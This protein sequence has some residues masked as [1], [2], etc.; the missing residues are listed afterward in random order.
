MTLHDFHTICPRINMLTVGDVFCNEPDNVVCN[1]ECLPQL[2]VHSSS[3]LNMSD[4]DND[5]SNWQDFYEEKLNGARKVFTPSVDT[6]KRVL[7]KIPVKNIVAQY[8]PEAVQKVQFLPRY[9]Y[10]DKVLRIG[11]IGAIGPHKGVNK[12]KE[13]VSYIE[14]SGLSIEI[15][16]FGYTSDN[17]FFERFDFVTITGAYKRTE[18]EMLLSNYSVHVMF[19]SSIW[20]ETF[21]YTYSEVIR[22]GIPIVTFDI[23]AIPERAEKNKNVLILDTSI[24]VSAVVA[25]IVSFV[26]RLQPNSIEVG[27]EYQSIVEGY[28][29]LSRKKPL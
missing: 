27:C 9:V 7:E 10:G 18:L 15:V 13:L 17:E 24:E 16:I 22:Q 29:K 3:Y 23:G 26:E 8:H 19:L 2:G 11:F 25:E 6:Q 21:G 28:Y 4:F 12:I 5:V 1:K 14:E 20:P